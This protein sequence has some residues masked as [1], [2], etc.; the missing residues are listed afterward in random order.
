MP[1]YKKLTITD[2]GSTPNDA[3]G[4]VSGTAITLQPADGTHPGI[5]STATQSIAGDKLFSDNIII[6]D[7]TGDTN[8]FTAN[9]AIDNNS[10]I[11]KGLALRCL[12]KEF[13]IYLEA[14]TGKGSFG[15]T[16]NGSFSLWTNN[17]ERLE[18][19][20]DGL[21]DFKE[22]NS[23]GV[24]TPAAPNS[25]VPK[26]Y[27]DDN[28]VDFDSSQTLSNKIFTNP[29]IN[30]A[31]LS[32]TFTGAPIFSGTVGMT[33]NL[34][35][36]QKADF[37]ATGTTTVNASTTV[38]GSGT[39]F[40]SEIGVGD[41]VSVSSAA[42]TFATVTAVASDTSMTVYPA[43]GNGTSQ[44]IT[45][46]KAWFRADPNAGPGS[47]SM[48]IAS[49]GVTL[50]GYP[51]AHD[52]G[53]TTRIASPLQVRSGTGNS[54]FGR[55]SAN[56]TGPTLALAKSRS[57]TVGTASV[58][59]SGDN[60]G[61]VAFRGVGTDG[62]VYST[63]ALIV[64][65]SEGTIGSGIIPGFLAFQTAN[66]SGSLQTALTINSSQIA[67]FTGAVTV[68]ST[69]GVTGNFAVNTNKFNV[70]ASSGLTSVAS[71]LQ[72][73]GTASPS[74]GVGAELSYGGIASTVRLLGFDRDGGTRTPV[75]IDGSITSLYTG[76]EERLR[77]TAA[78]NVT[79]MQAGGVADAA[80]LL[81]QEKDTTPSSPTL[82]GEVKIYFKTDKIVFQY[83]DAST[84]RYKYLDLTGTGVTWVHTTSAP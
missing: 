41:L 26:A 47:T 68:G 37:S 36:K 44:T 7:G 71:T 70:T 63:G 9:L 12:G 80:T 79:L 52:V 56:S 40:L 58:I 74:A 81:L 72:V 43:L 11:D 48:A 61:N 4:S 2:A 75:A 49:D 65:N 6:G 83:N 30:A 59:T 55:Y 10:I 34:T 77:V 67:A 19:T 82:G 69:L 18:L 17:L 73:T 5:V 29:T 38:T 24:P 76:G 27:V 84:I 64:C 54:F 13:W 1:L 51:S 60:L 53:L 39:A 25:I 50:I 15:N 8:T 28:F 33:S 21:F 31:A 14:T 57:G 45:V 23:T 32:G 62:A 46:K 66:S 78:G 20:G 42:A 35:I 22:S 16:H 3:G